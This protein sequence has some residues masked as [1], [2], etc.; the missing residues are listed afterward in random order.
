MCTIV[1]VR[2]GFFFEILLFEKYVKKGNEVQNQIK[3][4]L[5]YLNLVRMCFERQE[6]KITVQHYS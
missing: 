3:S 5:N 4:E 2:G 6:K 1:A